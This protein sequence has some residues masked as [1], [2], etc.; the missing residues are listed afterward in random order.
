MSPRCTYRSPE[1]ARWAIHGTSSIGRQS[2]VKTRHL[3]ETRMGLTS[4]DGFRGKKGGDCTDLDFYIKGYREAVHVLA[5]GAR[6]QIA[7]H[8]E[9]WD[10]L[11]VAFWQMES[12]NCDIHNTVKS[13]TTLIF[14]RFMLDSARVH[15]NVNCDR[16]Y[17]CHDCMY[18]IALRFGRCSF[19]LQICFVL[20]EV[21]TPRLKGST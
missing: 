3:P 16:C 20:I 4:W 19:L 14:S 11:N 21:L 13:L 2:R 8:V 1:F 9:S 15:I 12:K 5:L 17:L 7:R 18:L 10:L 6:R